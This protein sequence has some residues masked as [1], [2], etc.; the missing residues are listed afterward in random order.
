MSKTSDWQLTPD[1]LGRFLTLLDQDVS[2][3]AQR[4]ERLR[5]KLIRLF[6]WR[7]C[8]GPED[9]ADMT[10]DRIV[11]RLEEGV[12]L[13]S[14]DVERYSSGV[15]H[16]LFL[17]QLREYRRRDDNARPSQLEWLLSQHT[18][19]ELNLQTLERCLGELPADERE[20]IL[21]YYCGDHAQRIR[22]RSALAVEMGLS[23]G[24][25]RIKAFRL[26]TKLERSM[27]EKRPIG[28]ESN[29]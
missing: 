21:R 29:E 4:Y 24:N 26:R 10:I 12:E 20:L 28:G 23:P 17:E 7:K 14:K 11:R 5:L 6:E 22:N 27:G 9:L 18:T 2:V 1:S 15:A 16:N 8:L 19:T 13:G 25:L 3:A